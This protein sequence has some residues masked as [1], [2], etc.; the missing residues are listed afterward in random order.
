MILETIV[1]M[2]GTFLTVGL[3]CFVVWVCTEIEP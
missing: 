3:T 2:V 1:A